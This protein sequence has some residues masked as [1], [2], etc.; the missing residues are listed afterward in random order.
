MRELSAEPARQQGEERVSDPHEVLGCAAPTTEELASC[1]IV[2]PH[3]APANGGY[4]IPDCV[5]GEIPG[6]ID[7]RTRTNPRDPNGEA[8]YRSPRHL[9]VKVSE[10]LWS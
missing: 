1:P 8:P 10:H 4:L 2:K 3:S 9:G 6:L 7:G 5:D